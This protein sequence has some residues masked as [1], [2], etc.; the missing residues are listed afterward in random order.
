MML[1]AKIAMRPKRAAGQTVDPAENAG[2]ILR[3]E[4]G[5]L[6]RSTPGIGI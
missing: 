6:D 1:R 2:R 3:R 5:K 4:A